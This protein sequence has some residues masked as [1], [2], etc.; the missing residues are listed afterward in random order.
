MRERLGGSVAGFISGLATLGVIA[1]TSKWNFPKTL[2]GFVAIGT[3]FA[4]AAP[5]G[6][7]VCILLWIFRPQEI[8]TLKV[9][10]FLFS[11]GIANSLAW[12]AGMWFGYN[13][14]S[15]D[16]L[17]HRLY[18]LSRDPQFFFGSF[19]GGMVGALL[20]ATSAIAIFSLARGSKAL[21]RALAIAFAGGLLG[22][23]GCE[24]GFRFSP[25]T[26][27]VISLFLVW[28]SG[29]GLMLGWLLDLPPR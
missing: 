27:P 4:L 16:R 22:A 21:V 24:V 18:F 2:Q 13:L 7:A 17:Y 20:T 3:P 12:L 8:S 23:A 14:H 25:E 9:V 28:Q 11:C 10:G 5:F 1:G 26:F 29:M 15:G 19:V 6:V